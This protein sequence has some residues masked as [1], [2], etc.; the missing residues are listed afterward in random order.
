MNQ[1]TSHRDADKVNWEY[2]HDERAEGRN[3][4][5]KFGHSGHVP[6]GILIG[7]QM[8]RR[9]SIAMLAMVHACFDVVIIYKLIL[10]VIA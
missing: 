1:V 4:N 2:R 7:K 5:A 9:V 8:V 10:P 6:M 3:A